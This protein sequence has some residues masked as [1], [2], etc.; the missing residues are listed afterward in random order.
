[1]K[2]PWV[3]R[4]Q[5]LKGPRN[6]DI[7][8]IFFGFKKFSHKELEIPHLAWEQ[9]PFVK[10]PLIKMAPEFVEFFSTHKKMEDD[11]CIPINHTE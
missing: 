4:R 2:N 9:R 7:D 10:I 5:D 11:F 8:I 1:M 3:V 6:I